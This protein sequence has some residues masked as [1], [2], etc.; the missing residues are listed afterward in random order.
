MKEFKLIFSLFA[1]VTICCIPA[2]CQNKIDVHGLSARQ[3]KNYGKNSDRLGDI[4]SA[5]DFLEPYCK[6]KPN[7]EELNYRLAELYYLSH[8]Y[9]KSE[10]QFAKVY[11]NWPDLYPQ[12]LFYE[13]RSIKSQGRYAD[14]KDIYLKFQRKFKLVKN[15]PVT[16]TNLKEEIAGCDMAVTL[17]A[18]PVKV[19]V[20]RMNSTINGP[21][22]EL[23]PLSVN[24]SLMYYSSLKLDSVF[25][26]ERSDS[27]KTP[28]RQ[29][30]AA[31]RI[32]N[33]WIGGKPLDA[34][35][36]IP[37]VET[38]NGALSKDGKRFYFTRCSRNWSGKMRCEI[39]L[40]KKSGNTWDTPE[41]LDVSINDP[42]YT[43]TQPTIGYTSKSNM[44]VLYFVSDRP[45][46]KG[47]YDIWYSIYNKKK[48]E[49][50]V[51]KNAGS[52]INTSGDEITP[53]YDNASR[54]LYF[55]STE[56]N[57]MGGFDIFQSL[58]ELRKW[59]PVQ[60]LGYPLNS[61]YD[62]L[63]FSIGHSREDGFMVSNRP[64]GNSFRN[65]TCCDDIFQ[66]RWTDFIKVAVTGAIYPAERGKVGR[67][68]DQSQLLAMKDSIKPLAKAIISLY[69]IDKTTKEKIFI[70][71]DTTK[72]NGIY[73]FDLL[74]DRDYKFEME[75][76][77]YFNEQVNISTDGINFTYTI[78]M[79]P[80]W[81]NVLPIDKPIVLSNIYYEF[82]K[83]DL[84]DI[85]KKSI[86][87]TL[88][89]LMEKAT[90][91]IVEVRAHTDSIGNPEYNKNLSQTRAENV[92]NYLI[93]KGID[94]KRLIAKGYG[95]ERPVAPNSKP[96]GSDNPEGRE[97]NRRTEFQIVGTLSS[98]SEDIDTEE[99]DTQ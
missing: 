16:L 60:N 26:F 57:G 46:G 38:G 49:F 31:K 99:P 70:N 20:E 74:P 66:Y 88:L 65:E 98:L 42:N 78:E 5:I 2:F 15:Q 24:D 82:N 10:K 76:S 39:Y 18:N 12:A 51:P 83:S 72:E 22:I 14:A 61:S 59:Q 48:D 92:V 36:N 1:L 9:P 86:D 45:G 27:V 58:G 81:V 55:S 96:D 62:D 8:D 79:P 7:D 40:A 3:L 75:G 33:D 77:Q 69:M 68:L 80:I 28:V 64:G 44:E 11:K 67:N 47:G 13:A 52:R 6:L 73:Y 84:S 97:K 50:S 89:E 37:G 19:K 30:Y 25:Y 54:T 90:D 21:H 32:G 91:I 53:Y 34:T 56:H 87:T 23:S 85:A 35:I 41:K 43:A 29:F 94:K 95:S 71:R 4:Y 63:Y 17:I 93:G